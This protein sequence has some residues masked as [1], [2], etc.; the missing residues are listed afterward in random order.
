MG[1]PPEPPQRECV[2]VGKNYKI[3]DTTFISNRGIYLSKLDDFVLLTDFDCS[4]LLDTVPGS[5]K[6]SIHKNWQYAMHI[7]HGMA[8]SVTR[9]LLYARVIGGE[10]LGYKYMEC[11]IDGNETVYYGFVPTQSKQEE[12]IDTHS[13]CRFTMLS[14]FPRRLYVYLEYV[15]EC[16]CSKTGCLKLQAINSSGKRKSR[17]CSA[18]IPWSKLYIM[19]GELDD[20]CNEQIKEARDCDICAQCYNCSNS[21]W[22]CRNHRV[23]KHKGSKT[24]RKSCEGAPTTRAV[25]PKIRDC[26][27]VK[28]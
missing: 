21:V 5:L 4:S 25:I 8:P 10:I 20:S 19:M 22:F 18:D 16:N 11:S 26:K 7:S 13:R 9:N 27:T 17:F 1:P 15:G 3:A 24:K 12:L 2:L 6:V 28:K 23:C 14:V